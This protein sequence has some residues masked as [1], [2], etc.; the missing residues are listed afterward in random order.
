VVT[1]R[2]ILTQKAGLTRRWVTLVAQ[3]R[4]KILI[5]RQEP[6]IAMTELDAEST[7]RIMTIRIDTR[8]RISMNSS[9]AASV[10]R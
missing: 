8:I 1:T 7:L 3:R 2:L 10:N 4:E 5:L 6:E 9:P